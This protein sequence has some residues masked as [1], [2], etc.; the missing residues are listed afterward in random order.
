M[1][2]FLSDEKMQAVLEAIWEGG[3]LR[4]IARELGISK[5]TVSSYR[6]LWLSHDFK[7]DPCPCGQEAVHRGWCSVRFARSPRRQAVL[8]AMWERQR[9]VAPSGGI[10]DSMHLPTP[11]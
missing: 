7:I 10:L 4:G 9:G 3:S 8:A 1:S 6:K 11:G 2:N 5:D